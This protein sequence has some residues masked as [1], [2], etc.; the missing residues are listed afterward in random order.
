MILMNSNQPRGG[1]KLTVR[2]ESAGLPMVSWRKRHK[3]NLLLLVYYYYK[4]YMLLRYRDKAV[5]GAVCI[6]VIFVSLIML[7]LQ[8]LSTSDFLFSQPI[9]R[10]LLD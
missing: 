10:K 4:L 7:L 5:S 2:Y 9:F 1:Y 3:S 6:D 8:V